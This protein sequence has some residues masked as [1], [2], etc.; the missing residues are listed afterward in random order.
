MSQLPF[1]RIFSMPAFEG[2]KAIRLQSLANSGLKT[3]EVIRIVE[4]IY[5]DASSF[6]FEAALALN[7]TVDKDIE[8]EGLIFYQTCIYNILLKHEHT[9][10]KMIMLGRTKF[11]KKIERDYQSIFREAGLLIDPPTDPIILWWDRVKGHIRLENDQ[12]KLER[13]REAEKLTLEFE[14]NELQKL[15]ISQS[16]KWIAIEDDTAGYDILSYVTGE[17]GL[18]NKLIEVKSTIAS[19]LRFYLTRNEWEQAQIFGEAYLFHIWDM[20]KNPPIL[21]IRKVSDVTPHVPTDNEKG[22]W[23]NV[24][25]PLG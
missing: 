19:P 7:D 12:T 8:Y 11:I 2:L 3:D 5:P 1:K 10:A 17:F 13:A 23:K 21:Y 14:K 4:R 22:K 16:P 20:Q 18:I 25:I 24:E 15:G 9:W 6:D